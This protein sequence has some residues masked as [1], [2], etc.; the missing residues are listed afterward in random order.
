MNPTLSSKTFDIVELRL[1]GALRK[2][3]GVRVAVDRALKQRPRLGLY[4]VT[5]SQR[6]D[7]VVERLRELRQNWGQIGWWE[8]PEFAQLLWCEAMLKDITETV[9]DT[10]RIARV[11]LWTH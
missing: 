5:E 2:A 4:P 3:T 10:L 9:E 6:L 8:T 7:V 11:Q 1:R